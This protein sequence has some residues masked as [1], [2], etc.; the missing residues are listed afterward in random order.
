MVFFSTGKNFSTAFHYCVAL[1]E[2]RCY[3]WVR[4]FDSRRGGVV[5]PGGFSFGRMATGQPPYPC[6]K[7]RKTRK[8]EFLIPAA[9]CVLPACCA[10]INAST[11]PASQTV[12]PAA[13]L[14]GLGNL[15]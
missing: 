3:I 7:S 14:N 6:R 9:H 2:A 1:F 13:S 11:W 5:A 15:F 4:I 12:V 8:T 10:A